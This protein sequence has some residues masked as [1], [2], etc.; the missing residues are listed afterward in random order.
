MKEI[1]SFSKTNSTTPK[2]TKT[3]NFFIETSDGKIYKDTMSGLWCSPLG[4]SNINIKTAITKQLAL[5]PYSSNFLGT[6]NDVSE[7]YCEKLCQ[8][9]KMD[10]IYLSN[11]GSSAIETAIKIATHI[12]RK[13]TC[14]VSKYSYHGS[15]VLSASA[16]DQSIN[17]WPVITEPLISYKFSNSLELEELLDKNIG[18]VLIE[19]VIGAGGVYEHDHKTFELLKK[20]QQLGGIVIFD[21]V[22]TGFGKTGYLFAKEK[23][24]FNPDILVLGKAIANGYFPL[25]ACCVTKNIIDNVKFFNHGFT[26]SGHPVGSAAGLAMLKELKSFNHNKFNKILQ[27]NKI[28]EHRIVGCMGAIEFNKKTDAIRFKKTMKLN[29]YILE[30]A[31]ENSNSICYCLPYIFSE[32]NFKEFFNTM[33]QI[34]ND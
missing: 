8:V 4:Y 21:E 27:H 30:E 3:F 10:R 6:N 23:Y 22:V 7:E 20:Y 14:V 5:N 25:A 24:N 12:S 16:S 33:E 32:E 31:S 17:N 18:F 19:P 28:Y 11:S 9:T 15:T 26:F 1:H 34:I 13:N 29:G 2:V